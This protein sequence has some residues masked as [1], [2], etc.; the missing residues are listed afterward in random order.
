MA[1]EPK[2]PPFD[3]DPEQI[4]PDTFLIRSVQKAMGVPLYVQINSMVI[5]GKE[6]I[7]I[8][9]GTRANRTKWLNDVFS[10]VEPED[11]RWV[12]VSHEDVDHIGNLEQVLTACENATL[13]VDW[14][15]CERYSN[16]FDFPLERCRWIEHGESFDIGDRV[17]KV[18]RPPIYDS[19]STHGLFDTSTG[20]YWAVDAF[21]SGIPD[22][23]MDLHDLNHDEWIEG[24]GIGAY[25]GVS[26]WLPLV[27]PVKFNRA[28]DDMAGLGISAI[29]SAHSPMLRDTLIDQAIER[30]RQLPTSELQAPPGQSVLDEIIAATSRLN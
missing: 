27:D 2:P 26:A 16:A 22:P 3:L 7:I 29:A 13:V 9:T 6:P 10:L 20:V 19:P 21:A 5:K 8:D 24:M 30:L 1:F 4:A 14:G 17:L 15:V 23:T 18:H 28:I 25:D 12:F 11:V